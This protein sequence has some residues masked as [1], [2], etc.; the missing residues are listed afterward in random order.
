[1]GSA[2]ARDPSSIRHWSTTKFTFFPISESRTFS[3]VYS[4]L[5]YTTPT[6]NSVNNTH[7]HQL[8]ITDQSTMNRTTQLKTENERTQLC[9]F[10][11]FGAVRSCFGGCRTVSGRATTARRLL[12]VAVRLRWL[13]DGQRRRLIG[14]AAAA[15]FGQPRR[16]CFG[17]GEWRWCV[18]EIRRRRRFVERVSESEMATG[19]CGLD[20]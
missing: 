16:G 11:V 4:I 7:K 14:T 9:N 3:I 8:N 15:D 6:S 10:G 1:M 5:S 19:D 20:F 12:G 18:G 17:D 2:D 13:H